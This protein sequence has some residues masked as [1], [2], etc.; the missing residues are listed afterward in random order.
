MYLIVGLGNPT[1]EYEH[2]RHNMGFDSIDL[3][4]ERLSVRINRT[5]CRAHIGKG[6]IGKEKVILAKPQTY[7]NLSGQSVGALLYFYKIPLSRLIVIYDDLDLEPGTIRI[8][9]SGSAGGHNGM[10]DIIKM[11][12]SQE[13]VRVRIG[14]G[15]PDPETGSIDYVLGRPRGEERELVT[16][17]QERAALAVIDIVESG[18]DHA[19]NQ[20]NG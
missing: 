6:F 10:K 9:K 5:S 8:R 14:I 15:H 1:K 12:G 16:Q 7:M 3:L 11:T 18:A 13:F 2:T 17:A 20:F 19:M 4:A